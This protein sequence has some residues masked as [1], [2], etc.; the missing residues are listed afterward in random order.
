MCTGAEIMLASS[1]ISAGG[2]L[3]GGMQQSSQYN[4]R[5]GDIATSTIDTMRQTAYAQGRRLSSQRAAI[6]KAGI[7]T[8]GSAA[9]LLEEQAKQ[10]EMELLRQKFSGELAIKEN[11][12]LAKESAM[13]GLTSALTTTT[14]A[15]KSKTDI[16]DL[17]A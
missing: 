6:G 11:K 5:A 16:T 1:A 14:K 9:V 2:S 12:A 7:K 15:F 13:K 10:D 4:K 3:L 8:T 17:L